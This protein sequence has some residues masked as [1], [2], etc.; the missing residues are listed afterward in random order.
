VGEIHEVTGTA[1]D[2]NG[3]PLELDAFNLPGYAIFT[4]NGDGTGKL[5]FAPL[6]GQRGTQVIT[7]RASDNGGGDPALALS[8][9]L[10]FVLNVTSANEPPRM[11]VVGNTV[12]IPGEE[13]RFSVRITDSDQDPLLFTAE[14]L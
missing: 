11:S 10:T 6:A 12:A 13:L 7:L 5:R 8:K 2:A 3:D 4:D 1:S 9:E 14:G